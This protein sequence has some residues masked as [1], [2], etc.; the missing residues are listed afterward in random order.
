[1]TALLE[2]RC[3]DGRDT[4]AALRLLDDE[5]AATFLRDRIER[6]RRGE[7]P[8]YGVWDGELIG[9]AMLVERMAPFGL[10]TVLPAGRRPDLALARMEAERE[11]VPAMAMGPEDATRE[12]DAGWPPSWPARKDR[13]D[14]VL[15][16]QPDPARVEPRPDLIFRA[17]RRLDVERVASFRLAMEAESGVALGSTRR[18]ASETVCGLVEAERLWVVEK[19]WQVAGCA[20][21]SARSSRHEQLGFA[22]VEPQLR[23]TGVSDFMLGSLCR[24]IHRQGRRPLLFTAPSSEALITRAGAL[25]FEPIGSHHKYYY[26]EEG[27]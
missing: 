17:A 22:Y 24:Q 20:A 19:D 14:E 23:L 13:R 1:M 3:L 5:P 7:S 2:A 6:P 25:G 11:A 12:A 4:A 9:L 18:I 27:R 15:F 16:E 10:T 26:E 21:I 8:A